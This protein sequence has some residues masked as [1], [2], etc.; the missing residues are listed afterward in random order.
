M[1]AGLTLAQPPPSRCRDLVDEPPGPPYSLRQA[2]VT[3]HDT[4]EVGMRYEVNLLDPVHGAP[5]ARPARRSSSG[6][7]STPSSSGGPGPSRCPRTPRSTAFATRGDRRRRAAG[8]PQL[9]RG[10][11]GRRRPRARLL[12]RPQRRVPRQHRRHGRDR[13]AARL[14]G[15]QRALRQPDRRQHPRGAGRRWPP[16]T[17]PSR[18]GRRSGSAAPSSSSRSAARPRYPLLTAA[19]ALAVIDRASQGSDAADNIAAAVRP[20]PPGGQRRRRRRRHRRPRGP[21]R[22]RPDRRR[23]GPQ[24]ARHRQARPRPLPAAL[25]ATGYDGWVGLEYKPT[26]ASADAFDWLPRERRAAN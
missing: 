8:G 12:A 26:G 14:P 5:A 13:R 24:R 6:R 20:V 22:P 19:D 16:R 15:V 1:T 2:E 10:R 18:R 9:L 17:S 11:H 4:E 3:F 25:A 21:D 7:A 23:P